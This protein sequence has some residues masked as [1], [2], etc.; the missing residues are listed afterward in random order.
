MALEPWERRAI[1]SLDG[2]YL[3]S[4]AETQKRNTPKGGPSK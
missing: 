2:R 3:A 4:V 1:L